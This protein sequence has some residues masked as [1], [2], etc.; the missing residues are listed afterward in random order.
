MRLAITGGTGL[1]GRFLVDEALAAGDEVAILSRS[2]GSVDRH[3]RYTLGDTPDLG[4]FDALIH[5]AFAHVPGLYRGGEG[6]DPQG[7]LRSNL[8]GTAALFEAAKSAGVPRVIFLSSRAVYDG[9][10]PGTPLTEDMATDPNSLYGRVK[11]QAEQVLA[12]LCD[13]GFRGASLRATGVY[14]PGAAHKWE[15]FFQD[16]LSGKTPQPRRGTEVHGR[17]L[18]AAVRTLLEHPQK[19]GPFN[20]SDILLDRRDL[21][22]RVAR[23]T[24]CDTPLPD[25]AQDEVSAM[26]C[27]RLTSLGWQPGGYDLLDQSLPDMIRA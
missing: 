21:L 19:H 6:D 20:V 9:L 2:P 27:D 23:L 17:D 5:C 4:G 8:D 12:D 1:V 22:A 25:A 24:G 13:D 10:P 18:A 14:G 7:F 16:F 15:T 3:L 11:L 26:R